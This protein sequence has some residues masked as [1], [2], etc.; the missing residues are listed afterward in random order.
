[1]DV[2]MNRTRTAQSARLLFLLLLSAAACGELVVTPEPTYLRAAGAMEMAPLV[3]ELAT[4]FGEQEP[5]ISLEVTGLGTAYGLGALS[6]GDTDIALASWL[7]PDPSTA[8]GLGLDARYKATAIARDAIAIIVHPG[9]PV[10]GL[11]LLQLQDLFGGRIY[12]WQAVGSLSALGE[13]QVVSREEGSGTRAAFEAMVMH[14]QKITP[15]AIVASSPQATVDYVAGHPQALGYVSMGSVLPGVR[16]L[17]IE[18]ELPT[19][20][21][22]GR[23]SYALTRELWLVTADP[24]PE[25]VQLFLD[26][27]LSP[28]GQQIVA[29]R[30][31]RIR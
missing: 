14:D 29:R 26:F 25:A 13:V 24:P 28:A 8:S 7:P 2:P 22:A 9:N 10:E 11:G 4:A 12:D 18:G 21:S 20:G 1:V 5:T 30:F 19:P 15:M 31:G 6:A 16:V 27:V 17:K 23:G 3:A